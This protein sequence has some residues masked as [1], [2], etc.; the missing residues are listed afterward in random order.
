MTDETPYDEALDAGLETPDLAALDPDRPKQK[1]E[2]EPEEVSGPEITELT[3]EER[4]QF[5]SLV[6]V[7]KRLKKITVL[8]RPVT[9][10]SLMA[11]D[12]IRVG[13]K[14]RPYRESQAFSQAYQAAMCA[15]AIKSVDGQSWENTLEANPDADV[16]FEQKWQRVIQFYPLVIQYI[17]NEILTLDAEFSELAEKLGKLKG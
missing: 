12:I 16:L 10:A 15:A 6:N 7:G 3:E 13:E 11:D 8:D 2:G 14:V 17:Y 5:S 4:Q 9:I 1:P